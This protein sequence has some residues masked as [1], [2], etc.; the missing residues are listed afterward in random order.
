MFV[1]DVMDLV[2][3]ACEQAGLDL[4][5]EVV[6]SP[7]LE[8]SQDFHDLNEPFAVQLHISEE[9]RPDR[10]ERMVARPL[11]Y[12]PEVASFS[13]S[14]SS[15]PDEEDK[16]QKV[17]QEVGWVKAELDMFGYNIL[18]RM[19]TSRSSNITEHFIR[20]PVHQLLV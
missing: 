20:S 2:S 7:C 12:Q 17:L 15:S 1:S 11:S 4:S 3:L 14:S 16:L 9:E 6:S 18:F 13:S 8:A 5:S 19:E 10:L